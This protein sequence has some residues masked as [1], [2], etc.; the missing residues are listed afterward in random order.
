MCQKKIALGQHV[1]TG[2]TDAGIDS[3]LYNQSAGMDTGFVADDEY[4]TYTKPLFVYRSTS[5]NTNSIYRP[6]RND[7]INE[8]NADEHCD[9]I[10]NDGITSKFQPDKSFAGA[11][12]KG[13]QVPTSQ[14]RTLPVQF[15]REQPKK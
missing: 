5:T 13:H 11:G 2:G 15:E 8:Y 14:P 12:G 7:T 10:M 4:N 3:R 6:T 1:D 9:K